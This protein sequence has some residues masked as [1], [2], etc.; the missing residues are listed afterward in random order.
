VQSTVPLGRDIALKLTTA[1]WRTPSG[2]S[3]QR[4][5]QLPKDDDIRRAAG[6]ALSA[7][8]DERPPERWLLTDSGRAVRD[9][10]GIEPDVTVWEG[11][12]DPGAA[13]LS[14]S[15]GGDLTPFYDAVETLVT[16]LPDAD[17]TMGDS[18]LAGLRRDG[19]G[20]S[21]RAWRRAASFV[22]QQLGDELARHQAGE[23]AL[24]RRVL[25]RDAQ[26][27]AAVSLV[28]DTD[29]LDALLSPQAASPAP[30]PRP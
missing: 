26:L 17:S 8:S 6:L 18:L 3:I 29:R 12:G 5:I 14:R 2:R 19:F 1:H 23:S 10:H 13:I 27:Q 21:D 15:L 24:R 16:E 28:T 7:R 9:A 20:I 25:A 4:P 11:A 22:E 30:L